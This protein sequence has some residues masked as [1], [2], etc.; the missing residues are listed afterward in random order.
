M[1][2]LL[3]KIV[4][5]FKSKNMIP[6]VKIKYSN[7]LLKDKVA[8]ITGGSGGI[9]FEISKKYIDCGAKVILTGR[10]EKKLIK[11]CRELG[12]NSRYILLDQ[13]DIQQ[14]KTVVNDAFKIFGR[15]DILVNSSGMHNQKHNLNF[16]N[17]DENDYNDVMDLNLKGTYFITQEV[18]KYMKNSRIKGHILMISSNRG[19]EPSWSPY[20]LS[21]LGIIG[22]TKGLA[23][24]LLDFNI[25]VNGIAP[26][27]TATNMQS[28]IDGDSIETN[29]TKLGRYTMPEEV[30]EY[31]LLL[32]S[33]LG[34]TIIGDTIYMTGG[35]GIID[36][37]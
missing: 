3:K 20:S 9:G 16:L 13:F 35:R 28:Y 19:I 37:R 24:E 21:K 12:E 11:C 36:V 25:I 15:I 33:D 22:L 29:Q 5:L 30:S 17:I 18:A 34:D 23:K 26:G 10:D 1:K 27:P 32:V 2:K 4:N 7:E 6:I 31:A 14:I 8:L